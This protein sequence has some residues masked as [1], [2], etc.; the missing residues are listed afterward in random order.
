MFFEVVICAF[1][2][3]VAVLAILGLWRKKYSRFVPDNKHS[4]FK[5]LVDV[6]DSILFVTS[7]KK[8]ALHVY[9]VKY[10]KEKSKKS[11]QQPLFTHWLCGV[12]LVIIHKAEAVKEF[13]KEK[14]II[15]ISDFHDFFKPYVGT[16]ILTCGG[17]QWKAQRKLLSAGF[18]SSML[19]GYLV[20]INDHAQKLVEILHEE[21]GKDFTSVE[22][23]LSLCSLDIVCESILGVKIGAM[24]KE[25]EEYVS[26]LHKLLEVG[27]SRIWKFWQWSDFI[28]FHLSNS[29]RQILP[30]LRIAHGFS[31]SIIKERK[32]RYM[33]GEMGDD[34]RR[35][36]CLLDV[37]LKLHIEDKVL[38]EEGV[39]QEVDTFI[40][41][42]HDTVTV[43]V[44]WVLYL[45]GLYPEVQEKLHQELDSKL[46]ADSKGP[47]SFSDLSELKYL[48]CVVKE[49]F[50]IYPPVPI[51]A[52]KVPEEITICGYTI[53][54]RTTV[55]V[56]PF[57]VHRDEDVFPDPEKFDPD[58]FLPENS[59]RIPECAYIPFLRDRETALDA[60]LVTWK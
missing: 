40:V 56:S 3:I 57:L 18:H 51:I 45:I 59:A 35:P 16:G 55:V 29:Y 7:G 30:H 26:S 2:G 22:S 31:R 5:V 12:R 39:R 46:G 49:C 19:K 11:R 60:V 4:V 1:I 58:R 24:Q 34:S 52:R 50:R 20:V 41:G 15:E 53:P 21:T 10:F 43:A 54:K 48:D 23:L 27:M 33:N 38:D 25:A 8:N 9:I 44:Q 42:G 17:S 47:L 32:G 37:L 14:R 28:F 13:F 6:M 36:K